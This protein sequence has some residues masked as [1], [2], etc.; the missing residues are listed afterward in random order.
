MNES[1]R[2]VFQK[3][4]IQVLSPGNDI[5]CAHFTDY[6]THSFSPHEVMVSIGM[7][8]YLVY[9]GDMISMAEV[10]LRLMTCARVRVMETIEDFEI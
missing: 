9:L 4:G 6:A 10:V 2:S 1:P 8:S 3:S 5:D 7:T